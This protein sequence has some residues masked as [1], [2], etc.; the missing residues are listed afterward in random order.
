MLRNGDFRIKFALRDKVSLLFEHFVLS[1]HTA[2]FE[3]ITQNLPSDPERHEAMAAR[4]AVLSNLASQWHT[5]LRLAVY[6][7][8]ETAAKVGTS[9]VHS[10]SR[11]EEN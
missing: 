11:N 10:G 7:M 1:E 2:I 9:V 8:F 5:V 3:D 6:S 4:L